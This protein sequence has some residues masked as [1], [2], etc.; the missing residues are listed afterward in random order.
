MVAS[1]TEFVHKHT[2]FVVRRR[3]YCR[4]RGQ[5]IFEFII[6]LPVILIFYGVIVS[7]SSAINGSINQ[8]KA[9][10]GFAHGMI[11]GN[12]TIPIR[13]LVKRN[14]E[15]EKVRLQG[16]F[17][18]LFGDRLT[19]QS[20]LQ[21]YATCYDVPTYGQGTP[22]ECDDEVDKSDKS[23]P[24]IRVKTAYG[25]CGATYIINNDRIEI[26]HPLSVINRATKR[27]CLALTD[28]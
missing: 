1:L 13:I 24:L 12:P 3:F 22:E 11:K 28:L 2:S 14:F 23:S 6:F 15:D 18:H 21:P 16:M 8:Q 17:V 9:T 27:G 4:D 25:L 26:N 5:A 20:P 7:I 10:R 19:T